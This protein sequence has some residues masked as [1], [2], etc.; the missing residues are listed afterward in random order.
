[1]AT[2]PLEIPEIDYPLPDT[3]G[4]RVDVPL[5]IAWI[6]FMVYALTEITD[7]TFHTGSYALQADNRQ[8]ID[9]ILAIFAGLTL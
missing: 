6:P 9:T 5:P 1:M 4:T 3:D 8:K 7:P 2:L